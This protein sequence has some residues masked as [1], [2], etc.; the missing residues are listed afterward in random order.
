MLGYDAVNLS[1][2]D[3]YAGGA[4]L[5]DIEKDNHFSFIS[6]NINSEDGSLFTKPF[7]IKT[8]KVTG[9]EKP[10]FGKLK[11]GILGLCDQRK[12]FVRHPA[13]GLKLQSI[14]PVQAANEIV[15]ELVRKA[16]IVVV[17][18]H[19]KFKTLERVVRETKGID[20]VILGGEYYSA[21]MIAGSKVIVASSV[22]LGKHFSSL[23]LTLDENKKIIAHQKK[24]IPLETDIKQDKQLLNLVQDFEKAR[25]QA[26]KKDVHSRNRN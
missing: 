25:K 9:M 21:K 23:T 17:M 22:S 14:D 10:P 2:K 24:S 8:L 15:P 16:D 20:V 19:G 7:V 1:P 13:D 26:T 5:K 4:F 18:Y 11:V 6:A 12:N 3:F